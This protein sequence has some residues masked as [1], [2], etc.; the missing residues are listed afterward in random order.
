[1]RKLELVCSLDAGIGKVI[2]IF[3]AA[4]AREDRG[5]QQEHGDGLEGAEVHGEYLEDWSDAAIVPTAKNPSW[6]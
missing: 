1:M 5:A 2:G 4:A 3:S 6:Q